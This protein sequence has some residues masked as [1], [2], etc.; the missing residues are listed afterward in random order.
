MLEKFSEYGKRAGA[1]AKDCGYSDT[2]QSWAS[3]VGGIAAELSACPGCGNLMWTNENMTVAY[4]IHC[5]VWYK[6]P[7]D[8]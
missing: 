3:I 8:T 6:R 2:L 7:E 1:A 5:D 4:C